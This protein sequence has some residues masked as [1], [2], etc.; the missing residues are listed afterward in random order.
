ML[1][2]EP[3]I[4][5][6]YLGYL[7]CIYPMDLPILDGDLH[8]YVKFTYVKDGDKLVFLRICHMAHG[9]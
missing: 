4:F 8:S 6:S 1:V 3:L 5:H 7:P 2:I 9:I